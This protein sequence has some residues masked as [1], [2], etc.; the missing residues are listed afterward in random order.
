MLWFI[1]RLCVLWLILAAICAVVIGIA[2]REPVPD[3]LQAFGFDWCA[4]EPCLRGVTLGMSQDEA[5]SKLPHAT[6]YKTLWGYSFYGGPDKY[7]VAVTSEEPV[8]Y[9]T[10]YVSSSSVHVGSFVARYGSP[11]LVETMLFQGGGQIVL[12]YGKLHV[13]F[14][15]QYGDPFFEA[16]P[17]SVSVGELSPSCNGDQGG[18]PWRGFE[19]IDL[20]MRQ[21]QEDSSR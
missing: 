17:E 16:A 14:Y 1:R 3:P 12:Q 4:G 9:I 19:S 18:T 13:S 10:S 7:F 15:L 6:D 20:L 8:G 2:R 5:L 21:A 11:C